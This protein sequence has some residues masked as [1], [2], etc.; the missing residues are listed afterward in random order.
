MAAAFTWF[1]YFFKK[2]DSGLSNAKIILLSSLRFTALLII[3]FLLLTPIFKTNKKE[4]E[5]PTILFVQDNSSS[6]VQNDDSIF[7]KST[8]IQNVKNLISSIEQD[9][10]VQTISMGSNISQSLDFS[11]TDRQTDFNP[12]FNLFKSKYYNQNIGAVIIASDGIYN[13]GYN[14]EQLASNTKFPIYTIALGDTIPKNDIFIQKVEYNNKAFKGNKTPIFVHVSAN[15]LKNT[16]TIISL[17]KENLVIESIAIK[18]HDNNFYKKLVFNI[19]TNESGLHKYTIEISKIDSEYSI[20]NNKKPIFIEVNENKQK[21]I[22][23]QNGWHPDVG[24]I[25]KALINNPAYELTIKNAKNIIESIKEYDLVILHQL[26][27]V[28]NGIENLLKEL[29]EIEKPVLFILGEQTSIKALNQSSLGIEITNFKN[30]FDNTNIGINERF[31]LFTINGDK[32][33][34]NRLPPLSVPFGDFN[35]N[36]LSNVLYFQSLGNLATQKPLIYFPVTGGQ[37]VG[38][39]CGEG[40]WRWRL[41]EFSIT[42]SHEITDEIIQ[43]TV[44]YLVTQSKK[45]RLIIE[46]PHVIDEGQAII[47]NAKLYNPSY[48]LVTS[49][50]LELVVYDENNNSFP[51]FFSKS[52]V[53]YNLELNGLVS[54][55]YIYKAKAKIGVEEFKKTGSFIVSQM[56]LEKINSVANHNLLFKMANN[57]GGAMVMPNDLKLIYQGIKNNIH[58]HSIVYSV[59]GREELIDKKILFIVLAILLAIEW[60]LRKLWGTR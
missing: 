48:E 53:D 25:N 2:K 7:I 15:G 27:S 31:S 26:P 45:D 49:P 22:L 17:K 8:Y 18:I 14:P 43:K 37:R 59:K 16:E 50:E 55:K 51:Y 21:I 9:Y 19:H 29:I 52:Q 47:I 12:L 6:I 1:L 32:D 23:I 39:I 36:H 4:V 3:G 10:T 24:A 44:Q 58:I 57:S 38:V 54:G 11:F 41:S 30:A 20:L 34:L 28:T 42:Q 13:K 56:H 35:V 5:K 46:A 40:I 60:F 33:I